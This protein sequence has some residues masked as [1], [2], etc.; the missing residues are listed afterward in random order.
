MNQNRRIQKELSCVYNNFTPNY[1]AKIVSSTN[2]YRWRLL[3]GP[4]DKG[5]NFEV[6]VLFPYEYPMQGPKCTFLT[7]FY[8]PNVTA[9]RTICTPF[10]EEQYSPNLTFA[11][12]FASITALVAESNPCDPL[13][14][15]MALIYRNTRASSLYTPN[16]IA[17][18]MAYDVPNGLTGMLRDIVL[19]ICTLLWYKSSFVRQIIG[20]SEQ[21]YVWKTHSSFVNS[22]PKKR[23]GEPFAFLPKP[24]R[25]RN[26]RRGFSLTLTRVGAHCLFTGALGEKRT[27][28]IDSAITKSIY[29]WTLKI[30]HGDNPKSCLWFGAAPCDLLSQCSTDHLGYTPLTSTSAVA[31]TTAA[32][33]VAPPSAIDAESIAANVVYGPGIKGTWA[34]AMPPPNSPHTVWLLGVKAANTS[35]E[36]KKERLGKGEAVG[37][38]VGVG[39]VP[40]WITLADKT[41]VALEVNVG[42][43]TLSFFVG[44]KNLTDGVYGLVLPLYLGVS[45]CNGA[46][47]TS[48]CFQSLSSPTPSP[49]VCLFHDSI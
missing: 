48:V 43:N 10:L 27:V 40:L 18:D 5:K 2:I 3:I 24:N 4:T 19:K 26:R 25:N 32:L 34:L 46:S 36:G 17:V 42:A 29:R 15:K 30:G 39:G 44:E 22:R 49:A 6:D 37:V 23:L 11:D 33:A 21:H 38:G 28:F 47:L 31:A 9:D 12:I 13:P 45:G 16:I 1:E 7:T 35:T 8:H 41:L 20:M 14:P